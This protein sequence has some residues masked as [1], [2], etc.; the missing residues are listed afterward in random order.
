MYFIEDLSN[1]IRK[2]FIDYK[3][4]SGCCFFF[5][6]NLFKFLNTCIKQIQNVLIFCTLDTIYTN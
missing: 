3:K 6:I 5:I 1:F 4:L 2:L